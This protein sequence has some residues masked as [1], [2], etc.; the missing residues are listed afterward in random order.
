MLP[1][2]LAPVLGA[3][4]LYVPDLGRGRALG[5]TLLPVRT[6]VSQSQKLRI[7]YARAD[8][9]KSKR[10]VRPLGTFFWGSSWTL[11][12]WC[13][14]RSGF[15][16]FRLD[17]IRKL[18]VLDEQFAPEPGRT[19]RDYLNELGREAARLLDP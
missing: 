2:H 14:L 9:K 5:A 18:E 10:V 19:L 15:R 12:A 17:R 8:G 3:T 11:T 13:E 7:S 4:R 16:N 1:K 6:A